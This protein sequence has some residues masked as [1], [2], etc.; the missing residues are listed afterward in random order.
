MGLT[1][2]RNI[3]EIL[4]QAQDQASAVLKKAG[5]NVTT[6]E[7]QIVVASSA[8]AASNAAILTGITALAIAGGRYADSLDDLSKRV[9]VSRE[10]LAA[11]G[12]QL[13]KG[14]GSFEDAELSVK[15]FDQAV[16]NAIAGQ[17]EAVAQ[18]QRLGIS[19]DQLVGPNGQVRGFEELLPVVA[20]GFSSIRDEALRVD[21]AVALFGRNATSLVPILSRGASG[22][23]DMRKEAR[24]LHAV[25]GGPLQDSA[26]N[27]GDRLDTLKLS[28]M[29]LHNALA[30]ALD[31]TLG[32]TITGLA[33][34]AKAAAEFSSEHPQLVSNIFTVSTALTGLLAAPG[35][36]K[37]MTAGVRLF[38]LEAVASGAA[39]LLFEKRLGAL[40]VMA[41]AANGQFLGL[42]ATTLGMAAGFGVLA[43]AVAG[44][45]L[46]VGEAISAH[47]KMLEEQAKW[48]AEN[49]RLEATIKS[50][51]ASIDDQALAYD[52]LRQRIGEAAEARAR[53]ERLR[54]SAKGEIDVSID[55]NVVREKALAEF[56]K[57]L[58]DVGKE[59]NARA[60]FLKLGLP[61][62]AT[63]ELQKPKVD[64]SGLDPE[65]V[66]QEVTDAF[67]K[68]TGKVTVKVPGPT[69]EAAKLVVPAP[70]VEVEPID[71]TDL[72]AQVERQRG[73]VEEA[74]TKYNALVKQVNERQQNGTL[75]LAVQLQADF[76]EAKKALGTE[77]QKFV[78]LQRAQQSLR[79]TAK[80]AREAGAALTELDE[81]SGKLSLGDALNAQRSE[82][83]A[84]NAELGKARA[85]WESAVPGTK[86]YAD[87]TEGVTSALQRVDSAQ[88]HLNSTTQEID[89]RRQ[90]A[91]QSTADMA[92][93]TKQLA[94]AEADLAT[95]RSGGTKE[96]IQSQ[97]DA[98]NL[99]RLKKARDDAQGAVAGAQ[100]SFGTVPVPLLNN[101]AQA[102]RSYADAM[103]QAMDAQ[104]QMD[105][106]A[107]LT[108]AALQTLGG[109]FTS[110]L[111]GIGEGSVDAAAIFK[112]AMIAMISDMARAAIQ[113][114]ILKKVISSVSALGG[115]FGGLVSLGLLFPGKQDGGTARSGQRGVDNQTVRIG[116]DET[117]FDHDLTDNMRAFL[118]NDRQQSQKAAL[119]LSRDSSSLRD[120]IRD[121]FAGLPRS[122]RPEPSTRAREPA[123]ERERT[124]VHITQH[125]TVQ[126]GVMLGTE[127]ESHR[128]GSEVNEQGRRFARQY[129][130]TPGFTG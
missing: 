100:V 18:F 28:T 11:L 110:L 124:T 74:R 102:T 20:D 69:I 62:D 37:A 68:A 117:I 67:N 99:E 23:A 14:G 86:A 31:P 118:K 52:R 82:L 35:I 43:A 16:V 96:N 32:R 36:F 12:V 83:E 41:R 72:N 126:A 47:Q 88:S 22:I 17:K 107:Q 1:S 6:F 4:I 97:L 108:G 85:A 66:R 24:D 57:K 40:F 58:G 13:V 2:S 53:A 64:A 60:A 45:A 122:I 76:A 19:V 33:D 77:S 34:A 30:G 25:M 75:H 95:V 111:S 7:K 8:I 104:K 114:A 79:D 26:S 84:A 109:T 63:L 15:A 48:R 54:T 129:V 80:A 70:E 130:A 121:A 10:T 71:A 123:R 125:T 128:L 51:T 9:L 113:A 94:E 21:S 55:V 87:A 44:V 103:L 50:T 81:A 59:L 115:P 119:A 78:D 93:A 42:R 89:Q 105:A 116:K 91:A 56:D 65:A 106:S 38:Q 49:E 29:G 127:I 112:R 27:F 3:V 101:A 92:E 61:I 5:G 98:Q 39:S 120:T 90:Q 73:V 46:V